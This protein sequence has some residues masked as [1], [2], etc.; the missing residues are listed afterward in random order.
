MQLSPLILKV[1]K[2]SI[3]NSWCTR[4]RSPGPNNL[5][6]KL[7]N[8]NYDFYLVLKTNHKFQEAETK[9][10]L[11]VGLSSNFLNT[12]RGKDLQDDNS[13]PSTGNFTISDSVAAKD[14]N[15]GLL[16]R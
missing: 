2:K 7:Y 1:V 9:L 14:S 6:P 4:L 16:R 13:D 11:S 12:K 8:H 3:E 10:I 15:F 5:Y